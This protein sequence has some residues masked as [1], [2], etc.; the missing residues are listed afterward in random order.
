MFLKKLLSTSALLVH[1][2]KDSSIEE[3][4]A[5][6]KS[7]ETF[8]LLQNPTFTF[9]IILLSLLG[10]SFNYFAWYESGETLQ[11]LPYPTFTF[12]GN[13]LNKFHFHFFACYESGETF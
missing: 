4:F 12:F 10:L 11:L 2:A 8:E 3:S 9:L 1:F 5:R 7:R 13:T 6:Y